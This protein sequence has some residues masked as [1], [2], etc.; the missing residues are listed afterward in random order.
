MMIAVL[1]IGAATYVVEPYVKN[2][3]IEWY[4]ERVLFSLKNATTL[5]GVLLASIAFVSG[6]PS[7]RGELGIGAIFLVTT[8]LLSF[9][10]GSGYM[11]I[12][13]PQRAKPKVERVLG[14]ICIAFVNVSTMYVALLILAFVAYYFYWA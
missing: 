5:L 12:R 11:V 1:F 8:V 7:T 4:R 13:R 2:A 9:A 3:P 14:S 10:L 6:N